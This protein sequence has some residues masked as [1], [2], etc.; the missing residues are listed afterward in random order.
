MLVCRSVIR[1]R[2]L[3]KHS[4]RLHTTLGIMAAKSLIVGVDVGGKSRN[5]PP[6]SPRLTGN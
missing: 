4:V 1:Y 2:V 5:A 6:Q 3:P